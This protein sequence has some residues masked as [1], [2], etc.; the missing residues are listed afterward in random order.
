VTC[1]RGRG[2]DAGAEAPEG[3]N[4]RRSG[5]AATLT[6]YGE[7]LRTHR[8]REWGIKG[9]GRLVT[10]RVGSRALERRRGHDEASG[11]RWWPSATWWGVQ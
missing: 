9:I 4:L 7:Q 2:H 11:R 3:G 1:E 5:P 10:F 8:G 6:C